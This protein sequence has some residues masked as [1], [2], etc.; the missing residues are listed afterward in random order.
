VVAFLYAGLYLLEGVGVWFEKRWAEY[1]IAIVTLLFVPFEVL[2]LMH[3]VSPTRL[4]ALILNLAVA[5]YMIHK[6]RE[7]RV[8]G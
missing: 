8:K 2:A 3:R 6:L 1:L 5:A 4:A 7:D